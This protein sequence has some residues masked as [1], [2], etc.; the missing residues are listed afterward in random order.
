MTQN[1]NKII[2]Y[3]NQLEIGGNMWRAL[4][5]LCGGFLGADLDYLLFLHLMD[6]IWQVMNSNHLIP[7]KHNKLLN[8]EP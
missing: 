1:P 4:D 6:P 5:D 7:I 8:K 2:M 3:H